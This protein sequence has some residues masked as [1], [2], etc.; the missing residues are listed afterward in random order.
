MSISPTG[1][2]M[3]CGRALAAH[4]LAVV[5]VE[6]LPTHGGS[7]R[8]YSSAAP[9]GDPGALEAVRAAEREAGLRRRGLCRLRPAS[10]AVLDGLRGHLQ[11]R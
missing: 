6:E 3:R 11:T 2:C 10:G 9:C 5:R 4:G 7:L 1:R 8:V